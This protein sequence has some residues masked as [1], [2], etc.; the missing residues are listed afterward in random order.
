MPPYPLQTPRLLLVE[1][2]AD[3]AP[4]LLSYAVENR[5]ALAPWEM[6]RSDRYFTLPHWS[7]LISAMR[8]QIQAGTRAH[9]L[10]LDKSAPTGPLIGQCALTD[11]VRGPFQAAY[12]GYSLDRKAYGQGFM[13]EALSAVIEYAFDELRLHRIMANY[14]PANVRSCR[15]LRRL[16]FAVEGYARDYLKI[17]GRWEDH[18]L[19]ALMNPSPDC[20]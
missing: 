10:L 14:M 15:V 7:E 9:F 2:G 18:I 6:I 3:D 17:A 1:P 8:D 16:G 19:T 5:E 11:I 20:D 13:N 12:L 4:R